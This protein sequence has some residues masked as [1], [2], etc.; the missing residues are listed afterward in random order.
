MSVKRGE[1]HVNRYVSCGDANAVLHDVALDVVR[2]LERSGLYVLVAAQ[3]D[4]AAFAVPPLRLES[5]VADLPSHLVGLRHI[6]GDDLERHLAP[7]RH[8]IPSSSQCGATLPA[9]IQL[10]LAHIGV[11]TNPVAQVQRD[12]VVDELLVRSP[13]VAGDVAVGWWRCS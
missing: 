4:A 9:A 10:G 8:T 1:P 6:S 3:E 11:D 7:R 12:E 13:R 2:A 5:A